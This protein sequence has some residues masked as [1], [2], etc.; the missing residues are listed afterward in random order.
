[1]Y[2]LHTTAA[3][4]AV[5]TNKDVLSV[6]LGPSWLLWSGKVREF[7]ISKSGK[8]Q[9]V[10]KR[11]GI[12]TNQGAKVNKNAEIILNCCPHTVYNGLKFFLFVSLADYL[13]LHFQIC[14]ATFVSSVIASNW[15]TTLVFHVNKLV[16]EN[17]SFSPRKSGKMN[18]A[19]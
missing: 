6:D 18:S 11:Q 4:G 8:T 15:K 2:I 7:Y 16:R 9:S 12:L 3:T 13:F 5:D 14:F 19:E 10:R 1:V 17:D